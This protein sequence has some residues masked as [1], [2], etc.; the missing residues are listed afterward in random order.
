MKTF[1]E[2]IVAQQNTY[3]QTDVQKIFTELNGYKPSDKI[4]MACLAGSHMYGLNTEKSDVDLRGIFAISHEDFFNRRVEQL[5]DDKNDTMFYELGRFI[6][7]LKNSNPTTLELL[8][9]PEDKLIIN[10]DIYSMIRN[11]KE[12]FISKKI[13]LT[14]S[15]YAHAQIEKATGQN[16]KWHLY[17]D[18]AIGVDKLRYL[19]HNSLVTRKEV[20]SI[21]PQNIVDFIGE[22]TTE[23]EY[24]YLHESWIKDKDINKL[25]YPKLQD[26]I[27]R[28]SPDG[29]V[30]KW[31]DV[32]GNIKGCASQMSNT[33]N[34]YRIFSGDE[35]F[36]NNEKMVM[37]LTMFKPEDYVVGIAIVYHDSF[38]TDKK[39]YSQFW[40]W[41]EN[42]N[43]ERWKDQLGGN[44]QYDAKNMSHCMRLLKSC[45]HFTQTGE[46][47]VAWD[48]DD[49]QE[50]LD[51]KNGNYPYEELLKKAK[52]LDKY[53][54][55]WYNETDMARSIN[56]EKV[57]RFVYGLYNNYW[58]K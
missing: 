47:K 4:L 36:I 16:K 31:I 38:L 28:L 2:K 1:T 12:M 23:K 37:W 35:D 30:E 10:S 55:K 14:L 13:A 8:F 22:E 54:Q 26:Y 57:D 44:I 46:I 19:L 43:K 49:R 29:K 20:M 34:V 53:C 25:H 39:R 51:I 17:E 9:A 11:N 45:V 3:S 32:F 6:T 52:A 56:Q 50:F 15:G 41:V 42:R 7:L 48:G 5:S 18:F 24:P 40:Q 33:S 27:Y 21:L 58:K